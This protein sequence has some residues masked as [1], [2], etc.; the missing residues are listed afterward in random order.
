MKKT[1]MIL[2]V[3]AIILLTSFLYGIFEALVKS[4]P[5]VPRNWPWGYLYAAVVYFVSSLVVLY[6]LKRYNLLSAKSAIARILI[7]SLVWVTVEDFSYWIAERVVLPWKFEYPFPVNNWWADYFSFVG[8]AIGQPFLFAMPFLYFFTLGLFAVY[9][10]WELK[11][12]KK[13]I[14]KTVNLTKNKRIR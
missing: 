5:S 14:Y 7:F 4:P 12:N 10:F 9:L 6:S 13:E 11:I 1:K 8:T 3:T 2:R